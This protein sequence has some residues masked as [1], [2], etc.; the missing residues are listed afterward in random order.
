M[1]PVEKNMYLDVWESGIT[2]T[3]LSINAYL[4]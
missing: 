1:D 2:K 4:Q 3:H